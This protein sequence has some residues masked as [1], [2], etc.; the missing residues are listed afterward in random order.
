[1]AEELGDSMN[2]ILSEMLQGVF[3][4]EDFWAYY[5]TKAD[6]EGNINYDNFNQM[7]TGALMNCADK[8]GLIRAY[9]GTLNTYIGM[10]TQSERTEEQAYKL[11]YKIRGRVETLIAP[12][13]TKHLF[14]V[15]DADGNGTMSKTEFNTT[16]LMFSSPSPDVAAKALFRVIDANGNGSIESIE[17]SEFLVGLL[18]AVLNLVEAVFEDVTDALQSPFKKHMAMFFMFLSG[19]NATIDIAASA[20]KCADEIA[21][22][23]TNP[24]E[25]AS[26]A[27]EVINQII[28]QVMTASTILQDPGTSVLWDTFLAKFN[29]KAAGSGK[30]AKA[31][32]VRLATDIY[33]TPISGFMSSDVLSSMYSEAAPDGLK[34]QAAGMDLKDMWDVTAATGRSFVKGGGL[35][36]L[37]EALFNLIDANNDN[38]ISFDELTG[39]SAAAGR[40]TTCAMSGIEQSS[41]EG[42]AATGNMATRIMA[43]FDSNSDGQLDKNDIESVFDKL[44][45]FAKALVSL[46]VN[47]AKAV[48]QAS[49][50]HLSVVALQFKAAMLG[51]A[52][53]ALTIDEINGAMAAMEESEE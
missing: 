29:E 9:V 17:I 24:G 1:M 22:L 2:A 15:F 20:A 45:E 44:I 4:V 51:G 18:T 12:V 6:A 52:P 33:A 21:K 30:I 27:T 38:E 28:G 42:K 32:A 47:A 13:V 23:E 43:I 36:R 14:K 26:V 25:E 8:S 10:A 50:V 46:L 19:G 49:T 3:G 39:L 37:F 11:Y 53:D 7:F 31:D 34:E 41:E 5:N 48:F 40:C 35:K 16:M